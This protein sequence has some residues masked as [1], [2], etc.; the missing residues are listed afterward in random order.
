MLGTYH[1]VNR[2]D[3]NDK[4]WKIKQVRPGTYEV[5]YGRRLGTLQYGVVY[6]DADALSRIKSKVNKGYNKITTIPT[7]RVRKARRVV[8]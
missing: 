4:I 7:H 5:A 8:K 1:M 3:N 6:S 2:A